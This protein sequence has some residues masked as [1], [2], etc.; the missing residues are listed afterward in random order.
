VALPMRH[1]RHHVACVIPLGGPIP[2]ATFFVTQPIYLSFL[3][4]FVSRSYLA[5]FVMIFSV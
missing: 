3:F 2:V 5:V 4:V 1:Q